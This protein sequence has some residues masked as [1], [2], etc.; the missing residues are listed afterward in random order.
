MWIFI[1][2]C[3]ESLWVGFFF[4]LAQYHS[5]ISL[6]VLCYSNWNFRG[7]EIVGLWKFV[8][9][10]ITMNL[11]RLHQ[12]HLLDVDLNFQWVVLRLMLLIA[13]DY[14]QVII[15]IGRKEL[16]TNSNLLHHIPSVVTVHL[17]MKLSYCKQRKS[18]IQETTWMLLATST[19]FLPKAAISIT[20]SRSDYGNALLW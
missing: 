12:D 5:M 10:Y 9:F 7:M 6:W 15:E 16:K 17:F 13:T 19:L 8:L 20:E 4:F 2:V 3:S 11:I 1:F 14:L 18:V